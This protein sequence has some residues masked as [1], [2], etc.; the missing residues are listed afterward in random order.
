VADDEPSSI[1][2]RTN[3]SGRG[4]GD[5]PKVILG[6]GRDRRPKCAGMLSGARR[7]LLAFATKTRTASEKGEIVD[8]SWSP[9][10]VG[11]E[12]QIPASQ[13]VKRGDA[14]IG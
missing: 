12:V 6:T 4:Y 5:L 2:P 9:D 1:P 13:L 3:L 8:R 14:G 10:R 11:Q 7:L